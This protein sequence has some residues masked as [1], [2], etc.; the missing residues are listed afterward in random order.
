MEDGI[1]TDKIFDAE[2][3]YRKAVDVVV[4]GQK[5]STLYVH[6]EL[7]ISYNQ[8]ASLMKRMEA[9]G[10]VTQPNSVGRRDVLKSPV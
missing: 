4:N 5:A 2:K 9:D 3:A 1:Y 8:A 10:V 7:A 6:R